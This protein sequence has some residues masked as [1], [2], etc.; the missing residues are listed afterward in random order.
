MLT[1]VT[2]YDPA[3]GIKTTRSLGLAGASHGHWA[4]HRNRKSG[5]WCLQWA[6]RQ[7]MG[8][9]YERP[10]PEHTGFARRKD[11]EAVKCEL[12]AH[13]REGWGGPPEEGS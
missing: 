10:W 9:R 12:R 13:G 7:G 1:S 2:T 11:A 6:Y 8:T 4:V 5:L 3:T